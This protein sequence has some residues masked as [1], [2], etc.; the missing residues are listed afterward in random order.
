MIRKFDKIN[1]TLKMMS[2]IR[3]TAFHITGLSNPLTYF[4]GGVRM[5][6]RGIENQTQNWNQNQLNP[7]QTQQYQNQQIS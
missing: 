6:G 7:H 3:L 4:A 1:K 5:P 2:D